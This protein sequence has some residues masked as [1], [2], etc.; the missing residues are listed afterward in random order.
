MRVR[1]LGSGDAFG[2]GGRFNTCIQLETE[3]G[4]VLIDCGASSLVAMRRF[5]VAPNAI[6]TIVISHLHGDHFGGLPFLILDAQL[7]SRREGPLTIAGPPGLEA[8]LK[9]T[10]EAL[11]P[12]SSKVRQRF[13]LELVE[14]APGERRA[15]GGI[16]VTPFEVS[17]P[18]GAPP[19]A[20]RLEAGG[21][22]VS[23]SGDTEWSD[24]LVPAAEAADLFIVEAY[25]F[26][27]PV[28]FHL[29]Y[30]TLLDHLE[31]LKPK[32]IVLTHMSAD[33][34]GRLGEVRH[35]AAEDG[36]VIEL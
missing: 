34:L 24:A 10:M 19:F 4:G 18:C 21:K 35:E 22:V 11:F 15:L 8:R 29:S 7:V 12:G 2:S 1:F 14:L 17:H 6:R 25:F 23:Y 9:E 32:R 31:A 33:M 28:K 13:P 20:L 26:E 36:M 27:K 3:T 30:R 16:A 5:G